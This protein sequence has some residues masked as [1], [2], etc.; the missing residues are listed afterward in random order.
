ME[1]GLAGLGAGRPQRVS[2]AGSARLGLVGDCGAT[3]IKKSWLKA[4]EVGAEAQL[5]LAGFGGQADRPQKAWLGLAGW[6]A[7]ILRERGAGPCRGVAKQRFRFLITAGLPRPACTPVYRR[8][9]G[10]SER[11]LPCICVYP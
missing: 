11:L 6:V 8:V 3:G 5:G 2:L 9:I 4:L 10:F 7:E 1:L